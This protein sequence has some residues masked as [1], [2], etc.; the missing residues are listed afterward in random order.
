MGTADINVT[1]P[2]GTSAIWHAAQGQKKDVVELLAQYGA[3]LHMQKKK[4]GL[5]ELML[6]AMNG[7]EGCI[8]TLLK[9]GVDKDQTATPA[10]ATAMALALQ[11]GQVPSAQQ[12]LDAGSKIDLSKHPWKMVI[13]L[14]LHKKEEVRE[15]ATLAFVRDAIA[16]DSKN[17]I[18]MTHWSG[19]PNWQLSK[20]RSPMSWA[21]SWAM[22]PILTNRGKTRR[23]LHN[24]RPLLRRMSCDGI[25]AVVLLAFA[26]GGFGSLCGGRGLVTCRH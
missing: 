20:I 21:M 16:N 15:A 4:S 3:N 26:R 14:A 5:T 8:S 9:A 22:T 13:R 2:D 11:G 12:L 19:Q 10:G 7:D 1:I 25:K 24:L 6:A 18:F 17:Q 23:R